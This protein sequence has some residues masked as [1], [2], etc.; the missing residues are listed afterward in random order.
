VNSENRTGFVVCKAIAAWYW[1]R[2]KKCAFLPISGNSRFSR[3]EKGQF[4]RKFNPIFQSNFL[5]LN[6]AS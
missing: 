3:P 2:R 6:S 1:L 5:F 4:E